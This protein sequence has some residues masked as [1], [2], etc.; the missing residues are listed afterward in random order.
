MLWPFEEA[1]KLIE[2]QKES[3]LFSTGYGPSGLPHAGTLCEVARTSWVRQA[4]EFLTGRQTR[5]LAFSDDMDGLRRAPDNVPNKDMLE[6]HL[7][8]PLTQIPDP[9]GKYESF[10]HHN[11]AMLREFLDRFGFQYEFGSATEYYTSGRFN[12][13]MRRVLE[14]YDEIM[15][16]TLPTLGK[17]KAAQERNRAASY[18]PI[19]PIHPKTGMVMQVRIDRVDVDAGTV[20]WTDPDENRFETSVYDGHAKCQWKADWAMRW[21]VLGVDYEMS[22]KDL[23]DSVTLSTKICRILGGLPPIN[24]TYEMFLD[25]DGKKISKSKGNGISVEEWLRYGT[26]ES[27]SQFMFSNPQRAKKLTIDMI[28][29]STDEYLTNVEKLRKEFWIDN[30]NPAWFFTSYQLAPSSDIPFGML[31]NLASVINATSADMLWGYIHTYKPDLTP[32]NAPY[33]AQLVGHAVAYYN[34][35]V[36][37]KKN[38]RHP[39]EV[40]RKALT[41]LTVVLERFLTEDANAEA[42]QYEVYEIGKEHFSVLKDW[43]SCLYEVLLGQTEGPRFGAFVALYGVSNTIQLIEDKLEFKVDDVVQII[44]PNH[45][46]CGFVGEIFIEEESLGF[47]IQEL[48]PDPDSHRIQEV[49]YLGSDQLAHWEQSDE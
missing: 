4:Y 47:W 42:I 27:L 32:E 41:A 2:R 21:Y 8:Q 39:S 1:Q 40:E 46:R 44:D 48:N 15:A 24:F 9:F 7:G 29:R 22:G 16:A 5:L 38:F 49:R 10:G 45:E 3:V 30:Q 31:L 34:D 36:L 13:G 14:T 23:I 37:P 28:P 33:L 19:M 12:T 6:Q 43:F 18:S 35:F 11:N 20:F 25:K 17:D 26:K